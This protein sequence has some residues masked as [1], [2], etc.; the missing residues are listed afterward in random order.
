MPRTVATVISS[1][2]ATLHELDTVYGMS[3]LWDLLEIITVDAHNARIANAPR[4]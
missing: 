1:R 3:D 2:L 4:D